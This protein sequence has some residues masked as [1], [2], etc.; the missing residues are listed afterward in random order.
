VIVIAGMTIDGRSN[1]ARI[2][3]TRN[4]R[5]RMIAGEVTLFPYG[6]E[7]EVNNNISRA[8]YEGYRRGLLEAIGGADRTQP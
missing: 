5:D 6:G 4:K 2:A 7:A 8:F 3:V 1:M